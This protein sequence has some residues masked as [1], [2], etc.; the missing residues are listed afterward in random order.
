ME[1][2]SK[3]QFKRSTEE[4]VS[5]LST[6]KKIYHKT[7]LYSSCRLCSNSVSKSRL[8]HIFH[9]SG[10]GKNLARK[11]N[12]TCG[13]EVNDSDPWPKVICRTCVNFVEKMWTYRRA[14]QESQIKLRQNISIKRMHLSPSSQK[15]ASPQKELCK[16]KPFSCIP[17]RLHASFPDIK[18]NPLRYLNINEFH[19]WL[20]GH[21]H[22]ISLYQ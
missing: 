19:K 14:C 21:K 1:H 9:K 13:I 18:S 5:R 8:T 4:C 6:P 3:Q 12:T 10:E 22:E 7:D 20:D 15:N 16:I 2:E 17:G 11:V